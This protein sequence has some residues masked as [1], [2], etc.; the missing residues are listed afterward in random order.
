MTLEKVTNELTELAGTR[1]VVNKTTPEQAFG[2][3]LEEVRTLWLAKTDLEVKDAIGYLFYR[4]L[5]MNTV[6][7][8]RGIY[9]ESWKDMEM[10][11]RSKEEI[12]LHLFS[13]LHNS[14]QDEVFNNAAIF[15]MQILAL[16]Y[17]TTL[18]DCVSFALEE[19]TESVHEK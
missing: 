3:V 13:S 7:N 16:E 12:K 19:L 9:M 2:F 8:R 11:K 4:F 5:V 15:N 1:S 18:E 17:G 14:Y 10:P 6:M